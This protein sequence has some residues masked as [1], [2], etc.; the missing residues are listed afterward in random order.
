MMLKAEIVV[1]PKTASKPPEA[2]KRQQGT[3][4]RLQR[5]PDPANTSIL[6]FWPPEE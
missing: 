3:T 5:D 4:Y 6:D 1:K 2:R